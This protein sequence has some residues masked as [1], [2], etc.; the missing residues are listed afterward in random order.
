MCSDPYHIR[1]DRPKLSFV[2]VKSPGANKDLDWGNQIPA[3]GG[4]ESI[5]SIYKWLSGKPH[6]I[7]A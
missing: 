7:P 3:R 1:L 6:G 2:K 5:F 4:E